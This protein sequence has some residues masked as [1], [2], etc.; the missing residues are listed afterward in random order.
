[1]KGDKRFKYDIGRNAKLYHNVVLPFDFRTIKID[2]FVQAE[3]FI[4]IEKSMKLQGKLHLNPLA[5]YSP[6][7]SGIYAPAYLLFK[8]YNIRRPN[9]YVVNFC[10]GRHDV[11]NAL[12]KLHIKSVSYSWLD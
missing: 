1:M 3:L 2:N 12:S 6:T 11:K 7:Q 8:D 4:K 5:Y 10:S 9:P